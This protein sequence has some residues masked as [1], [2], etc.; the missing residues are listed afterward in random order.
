MN[1]VRVQPPGQGLPVRRLLDR[2]RRL[3][4]HSEDRDLRQ[5]PAA[6][7]GL[8]AVR[9]MTVHGAKGL[10]F[11]VVHLPGMNADTIPRAARTPACPPPDGM[12]EGAGGGAAAALGAGHAEEQECLFYVALSRARDR[13]LLYAATA[14]SNGSSRPLSRFLDRL[15]PMVPRR[16]VVPSGA[17][18]PAAEA[19]PV[20]IEVE[21]G[22][23]FAASQVSLYESCP[24]RF[25]YTHVLRV[26][27]RRV[28]TA[29]MMMHEAVAAMVGGIVAGAVPADRP[30]VHALASAACAEAGLEE[31]GR[32]DE[33]VALAASLAGYFMSTRAGFA[34]EA[35]AA[36]KLV[37]DGHEILFN[38]EDVVLDAAGIRR[39]RRIRTGH[40]RSGDAT[41][42]GA[43]ALM[44]AARTAFPDAV[45]EVVHLSDATVTPLR[46][47]G[48]DGGRAKLARTL[49]S[50]ASGAF[51]CKKSSRTCPGC[52]GFF[53]CGPLPPGALRKKF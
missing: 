49:A 13:L 48:R 12:V 5:V 21:G 18:P 15:G 39:L 20:A 3:V 23:R 25:L 42:V 4:R 29:F 35:P 14:R 7:Q 43:S 1:F 41:D 46:P 45:V 37:V 17:L 22:L 38:P 33:Y 28:A 44:L 47:A 50:I 6:A 24:R 8:D 51:P 32:F 27:G 30:A 40:A 34:H 16:A 9:L 19:L 10:E 31:D 2:I 26:G 52:P 53:I 36:L 11:P